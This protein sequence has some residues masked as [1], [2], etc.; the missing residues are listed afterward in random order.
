MKCNYCGVLN[1][2]EKGNCIKCG[3]PLD[4]SL[5]KLAGSFHTIVRH[6]SKTFLE[7]GDGII[8]PTEFDAYVASWVEHGWKVKSA[9]VVNNEVTYLVIAVFLATT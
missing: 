5:L 1:N 8:T 9:H 6:V 7:V 3:A 4:E 2:E